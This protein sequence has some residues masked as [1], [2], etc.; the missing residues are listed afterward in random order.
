[1]K[2]F[3]ACFGLALSLNAFA[4]DCPVQFG[5]DGY[6]EK[7]SAAIKATKSCEEGAQVAEACALG[8]SGDVAT[9]PVAERKCG[10]DFWTKLSPA[11][12]QIYN[13][14]QAKCDA[15]YKNMQGTMYL[16][17]NAFCRLQ[18]ARLY[19]ELYTKAE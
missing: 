19:S 3:F 15:K 1:L 4:A 14:L 13:G 11:E 10:L 9:V 17:F 5:T 12:K 7:V 6:L 8:A 2:L 16:S 18:V